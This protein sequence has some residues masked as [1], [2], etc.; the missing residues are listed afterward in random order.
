MD[1]YKEI[2]PAWERFWETLH[3][4][5]SPVIRTNTLRISP[6]ELQKRL[7]AKGFR[8]EPLPWD[9]T[10]FKVEDVPHLDYNKDDYHSRRWC[11]DTPGVVN[12][13][14]VSI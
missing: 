8:L 10:A 7:E 12:P 14:Q 4:P 5:L 3:R 13:H 2:I 1:R 6:L 9:E 11:Y